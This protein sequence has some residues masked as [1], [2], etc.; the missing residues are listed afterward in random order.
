MDGKRCE[1]MGTSTNYLHPLYPS[2]KP[3][4]ITDMIRNDTIYDETRL[5]ESFDINKRPF[6]SA[7]MGRADSHVAMTNSNFGHRN[8]ITFNFATDSLLKEQFSPA[9]MVNQILNSVSIF[10]SLLT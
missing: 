10:N 8:A 2:A 3:I 1:K 5:D 6:R 7:T 9:E 4:N